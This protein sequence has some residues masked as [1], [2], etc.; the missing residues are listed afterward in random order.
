MFII[1]LVSKEHARKLAKNMPKA[2]VRIGTFS[3][4]YIGKSSKPGGLW[5][6]GRHAA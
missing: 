1:I 4:Q 3:F 5:S 2:F 6:V